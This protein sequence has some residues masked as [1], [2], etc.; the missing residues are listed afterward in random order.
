MKIVIRNEKVEKFWSK[1]PLVQLNI[2]KVHLACSNFEN[3]T[4]FQISKFDLQ[5][6][7]NLEAEVS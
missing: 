5:E 6:I 2:R 1:I 3:F 4:N 7:W